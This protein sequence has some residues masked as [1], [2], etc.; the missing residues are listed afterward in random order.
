MDKPGEEWPEDRSDAIGVAEM[1]ITD[2]A[3]T[4]RS[5]GALHLPVVSPLLFP[6]KPCQE[7][8]LGGDRFPVH[9]EQALVYMWA[10]PVA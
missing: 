5:E 4:P 7:R 9:R 2:L 8:V 6:G 3:I 1:L 10:L